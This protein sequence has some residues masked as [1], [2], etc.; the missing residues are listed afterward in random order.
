MI[1]GSCGHKLKNILGNQI[2]YKDF[3]KDGSRVTVYATVCKKCLGE[4]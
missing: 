1:I 3:D 4:I 2:M